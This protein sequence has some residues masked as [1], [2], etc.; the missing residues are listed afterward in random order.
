MQYKLR[1][2]ISLINCYIVFQVSGR[3]MEIE[4]SAFLGLTNLKELDLSSGSIS[5]LPEATLCSI[6]K[7]TTVKLGFNAFRHIRDTGL[8]S[9]ERTTGCMP[10]LRE[11]DLSSNG[12]RSLPSGAFRGLET[13]QTIQLPYN[14]ISNMAE[15]ALQSL[16]LLR[17]LDISHNKLVQVQPIV[18][19]EALQLRTLL[20][21]NNLLESLP[22]NLFL[23]Q[24]RLSLLNISHN[25]LTSSGLLGVLSGC[26]SL[27]ML[28]G[29]HNKLNQL[30]LNMF[31]SLT[32]L[33]LLDFSN[34]E[35]EEIQPRA[36]S[37]MSLLETLE[38]SGNRIGVIV[39][40]TF[41]GLHSLRTV[42]LCNNDITSIHPNVFSDVKKLKS[43][44][45]CSNNLNAVPNLVHLENLTS[46]DLS[47]NRIT[48][49]Y[50]QL[51]RGLPNLQVCFKMYVVVHIL[52]R[53]YCRLICN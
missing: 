4:K 23:S 32:G 20:L 25:R 33:K 27:E 18:F 38:L 35:I 50:G 48:S 13:L 47:N 41:R 53:I 26:N 22:E 14:T 11:I 10:H 1:H 17:L 28:D 24:Q 9:T 2:D 42:N 6:P 40:G 34:N 37:E 5:S 31:N 19:S 43:I 46:L 36:F 51:F 30:N 7:L 44:A 49:V 12:L 52:K 39:D 8:F 16:H 15:G 29:S 3:R 21:N 45:L